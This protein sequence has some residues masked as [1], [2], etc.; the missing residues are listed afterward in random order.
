MLVD[1]TLSCKRYLLLYAQI[2]SASESRRGGVGQLLISAIMAVLKYK[3]DV[4]V[5]LIH[6]QSVRI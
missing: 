3:H 5:L 2:K 1:G 6:P 4:L